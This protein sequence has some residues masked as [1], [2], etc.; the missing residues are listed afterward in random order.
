MT[1]VDPKERKNRRIKTLDFRKT[2][3]KILIKVVGR[4]TPEASVTG[5]GARRAGWK[6][7]AQEQAISMQREDRKCSERA[8][9]LN[10]ELSINL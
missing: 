9:W 8:V 10:L 2:D 3:L 4:M 7:W 1:F 6:Y 5:K